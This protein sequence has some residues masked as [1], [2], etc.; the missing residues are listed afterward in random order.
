VAYHGFTESHVEEAALE[1]LQQVGYACVGGPEI[2]PG[3]P[4]AERQ[5]YR[6][7]VLLDRLRQALARLNP[8]LPESALDDAFRQVTRPESPNP[9]V[10]NHR[11]HR[12]LVEGVPVSYQADDGRT[13]YAHARLADF[14]DPSA[15]DWLAVNQ[16]SVQIQGTLA[17]PDTPLEGTRRP[18]IVLFLNGLPICVI[19]LKNAVDENASVLDAYHQLDTY[20]AELPDLFVH[21]EGLVASD[22]T[23]ARMGPLTA[24]WEWFKAWRTVDGETVERA[25]PPLETLIRGALA[26]ERYL[27]RIR[28]FT[29]YEEN[30][31]ETVK[32]IASYHQYHAA[33]KAVQATLEATAP[34]GDGRVGVVWHTQGSGKSLTMLFYAGKV[35]QAPPM[36]NPTLVVLTDRNDL[37]DQLYDVFSLGHEVLRQTPTQAES[38]ED[39]RAKL[40]V[41]SGGVVFTTIQKFLPEGGADEHPELSTRRNIVFIVDEAHRTQYGFEARFVEREDGL[42]RVYGLAKYMRD[43]LPNAAFVGFTGTPVSATDRN[44]RSV[45]GEYIDVYDIQRAV[46]DKATVPIYYDAR[47]AKIGLD[48]RM[49]PL[50]DPDFDEVTEGEEAELKEQLKGKWAQLAAIVGDPE[51]LRQVAQ[52]IVAHYELRDA[53]L[54]G[55]AMIVCMTRAICVAMYEQLVSLRP[56]W[57]DAQ[58]DR[59]VLKVV[60]TG[61]AT[62]GP[63]WQPHIRNKR[64]R[65]ELAERFRNPDTDFKVVIVR[66]MWLTGFDAPSLHTMYVDKPMRGLNLMQAIARVNRVFPGKEGGLVVAYLPLA[67][68]L[69]EALKDYTEDDRAYAGRL[70]DEAA[71]IMLE[72]YDVVKSMMHGFDYSGFFDERPTERL[73]TLSAAVDH[74]LSGR[75]GLRQRY[76]DA[77][78]AL[79]RA[80]ALANP[81]PLALQIRDEV[82]FFQA[83]KAPLVKSEVTGTTKT[84]KTRQEL[85]EAIRQIVAKAIAPEG[86]V[87]LFSL[88]GLPQPDI[89]ILSEEFLVEVQALP[90][91]NLA[92][93]LLRRLIED[94]IRSRRKRNLVQ[95]RSFAAMLRQ[96]LERYNNQQVT[97]T[98]ILNELIEIAREMREARKHGDALGLSEEELAFYDA[99]AN[100]KSAV[101]VMGDE[102]LAFIAKAL[103]Q[104]VRKNVS[105]DWTLRESARARIRIVVKRILRHYGYP[106][107]LQEAAMRTVLEQAELLAAEWAV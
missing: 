67:T 93:E 9:I 8:E 91:R 56:E 106:P 25:R 11:F 48:E 107:D 12:L 55:K 30:R 78:T 32:K 28:F 59:G 69:Q 46:E 18:D 4:G 42:H 58:D 3:E 38:R 57:H 35:V 66:D 39:M 44:T 85:D 82:G 81:H 70:Q 40:A 103:I 7:V 5:S 10:N 63:E 29:V 26:P 6:E 60:M 102:Q 95:S 88:A 24:G 2:A 16:F 101:E 14:D 65:K 68:Q 86:V 51:R 92:L 13:A 96:A 72:K 53:T 94:E 54:P 36:A 84:G 17:N 98:K 71:E 33:N 49:A 97:A 73:K 76:V 21:N 52:D 47:H 64:R 19:E 74:I 80:F 20:K 83:V 61:S 15:N 41:A 105:I 34:N 90:Q 43:A 89:S 31:A 75:E 37:D 100:N 22:G 104:A 99:L 50:I 62:D 27:D 23:D 79:G 77:V 1:W 45:F 87:D